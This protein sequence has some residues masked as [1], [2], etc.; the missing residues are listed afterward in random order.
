MKKTIPAFVN[1]IGLL[2]TVAVSYLSVTGFFN[3]NTMSLQSARHPSLFTPAPWA[4]SIWGLI[5]LA[6]A[7]F[8]VFQARGNDEA[9]QLRSRVGGW[10]LLSCLANSCWVI[11]W[12][13]DLAGISVLLMVVLLLSLFMIVVRTDMELTDPPLRTIAFVWWPFCLYSGWITVALLANVS[14][15]IGSPVTG[16]GS[17]IAIVMALVAGVAYLT[18]TWRRNMREYALV[19]AFALVAVGV[20]DWHRAPVVSWVTFVVAGILFISSG[21]HAWKNRAYSPFRRRD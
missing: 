20:A 10:F 2:V 18:M 8:V 1:I 7:G 4:F 3:H 5:Y 21:W 12:M 19:G 9:L 13:Y 14:A 6:L 16:G 15:V 11:A 17:G